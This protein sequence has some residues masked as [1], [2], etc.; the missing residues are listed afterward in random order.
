MLL[1]R[2]R[3]LTSGDMQKHPST[4]EPL[5]RLARRQNMLIVD[6]HQHVSVEAT[7]D[8]ARSEIHRGTAL[9]KAS[10]ITSG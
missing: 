6:V 9:K 1:C 4:V 3:L 10:K 2:L 8:A 7:L 5:L